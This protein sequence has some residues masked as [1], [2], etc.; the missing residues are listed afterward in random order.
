MATAWVGR[1]MGKFAASRQTAVLFCYAEGRDDAWEGFCLNYDLVVQGSSFGD[2]RGK[3]AETIEIYRE[4]VLTLPHADQ[5]RSLNRRTPLSLW[6][7]PL[8]HLVK[9]AFT[10]RDDRRCHEFMLPSP[11]AAAPA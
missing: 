5:Q 6:L 11:G 1:M 3:L 8:L 4:G 2:V 10:R 9:T 7:T